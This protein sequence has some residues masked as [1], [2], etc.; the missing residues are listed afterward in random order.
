VASEA[1]RTAKIG[2]TSVDDADAEAER[3][4][5]W[6]TE[7]KGF[8]VRIAPTGTKTYVVRYRAGGGRKGTLRQ[9]VVGRHGALTADQARKQAKQILGAATLGQDPQF[10]KAKDR[11]ELTVSE[12]CDLYMK[13]GVATKKGEH[14]GDRQDPDRTTHQTAHRQVA[15]V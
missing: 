6:D 8:G 11:A 5:L 14:P 9:Q 15:P 7:L 1:S 2:K 12:L 4:T 10:T 13:E 3:Y